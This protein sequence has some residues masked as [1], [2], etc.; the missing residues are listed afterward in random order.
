MENML[1]VILQKSSISKLFKFTSLPSSDRL[2]SVYEEKAFLMWR[3]KRA[4][5]NEGELLQ[6]VKKKRSNC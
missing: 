1:K 4:E 6:Q 2:S 5:K 3:R